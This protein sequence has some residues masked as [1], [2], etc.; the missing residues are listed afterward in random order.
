[1]N[2]FSPP[3]DGSILPLTVHGLGYTAGGKR[4]GPRCRLHA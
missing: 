3:V 1:M 4:L 2:D